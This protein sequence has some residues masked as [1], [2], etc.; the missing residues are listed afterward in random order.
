[1]PAELD[2]LAM[3]RMPQ[4]VRI[5][6]RASSITNSFIN[7][8]IPV[9]PPT[10]AEVREALEILGMLDA[11]ACAYCGDPYTEWD[12]LRPLVVGKKP[13]G[14]VSEIHNLVP[15]CGKCNQ[16]KGNR[17][18]REWMFGPARLSPLTRGKAGLESRAERLATYE[19]WIPPTQLDF[20]SLVG[21][22]VWAKHW[23]NYEQIIGLMREAQQTATAIRETIRA[24]YPSVSSKESP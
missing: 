16:S 1:M 6:G 17:Y 5:T 2:Y 3:F 20:E 19:S 11:I 13:T 15:A 22:E 8:I 4:P 10:A 12:H 23:D 21:A 14:Y 9:I 24:T 18:W 7:A